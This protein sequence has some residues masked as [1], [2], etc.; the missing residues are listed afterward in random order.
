MH[1][2]VKTNTLWHNEPEGQ[3]LCEYLELVHR[4]KLQVAQFFCTSLYYYSKRW[5]H[6]GRGLFIPG[7][8]CCYFLTNITPT[9]VPFTNSR[10]VAI[11][12]IY[13]Y[14]WRLKAE[15]VVTLKLSSFYSSSFI[16]SYSFNCFYMLLFFISIA[17]FHLPQMYHCFCSICILFWGGIF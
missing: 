5:M 6:G 1:R 8:A 7:S 12:L 4:D 9:F 3:S 11:S 10:N 15:A 14:L 16:C 17:T 2:E 13:T